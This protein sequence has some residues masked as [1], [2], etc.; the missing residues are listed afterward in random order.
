MKD[1]SDAPAEMRGI[2]HI[3][4]IRSRKAKPT[5]TSPADEWS[6]PAAPSV[7]LNM[8]GAYSTCGEIGW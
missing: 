2:L 1:K 7:G 4:S 5:F 8:F 3:I 6:L